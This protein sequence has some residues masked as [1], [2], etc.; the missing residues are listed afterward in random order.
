MSGFSFALLLCLFF[1]VSLA[2]N[3]NKQADNNNEDTKAFQEKPGRPSKEKRPKFDPR[4]QPEK[5]EREVPA[6]FETWDDVQKL[7]WKAENA[8]S[9]KWE[10]P[11]NKKK[12]RRVKKRR[13]NFHKGL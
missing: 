1:T 8:D 11:R 12:D 9:P 4:V 3:S 13:G 7:K 6:E 2:D 10:S 5:V